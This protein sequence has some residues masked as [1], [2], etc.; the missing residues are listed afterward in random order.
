MRAPPATDE[1]LTPPKA[2]ASLLERWYERITRRQYV[3]PDPVEFV[4]R[5]DDPG[6]QEIAGLLAATLAYGN[7]KA[8]VRSVGAVLER[9]DNRPARFVRDTSQ[10]AARRKLR[11]F[12]HRWTTGDDVAALLG[13]MNRE[14]ARFGSLGRCFAAGLDRGDATVLPA[15]R[16]FVARLGVGG[17][18][19]SDPSRGSAC[20][21]LHLYLRWMVRRDAVDVGAWPSV[22]PAL[23]VI[24][25]DVHMHSLGRA[26][27]LTAR[28]AAD[29]RTAEEITAAFRT[30]RPEDPVRYDFCLTRLGLHPEAN[31]CEFLLGGKGPHRGAEGQR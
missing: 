11:G 24:P 9:M 5:F 20:K 16:A 7:V 26:M 21:R 12:Q 4:H 13:A 1:P 10:A 14:I 6:D 22:P 30:I 17:R 28:R 3:H 8:V 19:L 2:W 18:M 27:G 25:L 29:G 23:L 15:L 31:P